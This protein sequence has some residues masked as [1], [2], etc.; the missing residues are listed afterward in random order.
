MEDL[1]Q[2]RRLIN[3]AQ[4]GILF[5]F[6]NPGAFQE[7]P[8]QWTLLQSILYR[9]QQESNP[10]YNPN[11]YMR[12]VVN[13]QIRGLTEDN[14]PPD[15]Q[16]PTR[17]AKIRKGRHLDPQLDPANPVHPVTLITGGVQPPLRLDE[18]VQVPANIKAK[19]HNW[20]S[21]L[22]GA[23]QV[24]IHSKCVVIDPFGEH[25]VVITGSHNLGAK[26]SA[27]N[28]DNM[29]IIEGNAALAQAY[30]VNIIAIF[31]EYRFRHYVAQHSA[32]PNAWHGLE[33]NDTWQQG[34]L[35]GDAEAE[36][37]FWLGA[38]PTAAGGAPSPQKPLVAPPTAAPARP[39]PAGAGSAVPSRQ[40]PARPK[41]RAANS[42]RAPHKPAEGKKSSAKEP[43]RAGRKR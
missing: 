1:Q 28:D 34:H 13:Q 30:A 23:S 41:A 14:V 24:M 25:P 17:V 10:N 22:L 18:D 33:D 4:E 2:A 21:E 11:L 5:L 36:L 27:K 29:V 7:D 6:F 3:Q 40:Q 15:E 37:Q 32:D 39:K 12:G 31:D 38:Q 8:N 20:V 9:H 35:T 43:H 42:P 26:A 19:F 16:T